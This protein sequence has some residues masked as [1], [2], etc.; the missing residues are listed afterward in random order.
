M[1]TTAILSWLAGLFSALLSWL[2]APSVPSWVSGITTAVSTV[3]TYMASMS[4]WF[5]VGLLRTILL[6]WAAAYLV[7]V[8]VRLARLVVSL[9]TGGGGSVA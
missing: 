4:A 2:P 6:A 3:V 7:A 9:F 1:I 8:A 5:P